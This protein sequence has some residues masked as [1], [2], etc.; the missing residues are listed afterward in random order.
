M[1]QVVS[2]N[3]RNTRYRWHVKIVLHIL[4][5][6]L[7][8]AWVTWRQLGGGAATTLH[9]WELLLIEELMDGHNGV[10]QSRRRP[11]IPMRILQSPRSPSA[12]MVDATVHVPMCASVDSST[13]RAQRKLCVVCNAKVRYWCK[14]CCVALCLE[15]DSAVQKCWAQFHSS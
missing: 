14:A 9:E 6:A 7:C 3:Y 2:H 10:G 11:V 15:T 4:R 12:N 1:D 5:I 13:G 8:N